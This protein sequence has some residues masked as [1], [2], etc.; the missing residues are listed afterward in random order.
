MKI[1]VVNVSNANT[2]RIG[3]VDLDI[4]YLTKEKKKI[5][6]KGEYYGK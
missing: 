1:Y 2:C 4:S 6:F 5:Y 3:R